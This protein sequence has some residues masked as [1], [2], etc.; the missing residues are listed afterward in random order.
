MFKAKIKHGVCY[1][2]L[3]KQHSTEGTPPSLSSF[4]EALLKEECKSA[5][6]LETLTAALEKNERSKSQEF[7]VLVGN[8]L[9]SYDHLQSFRKGDHP[10]VGSICMKSYTAESL[11]F[12]I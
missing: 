8:T 6:D 9:S 3:W 11:V 12:S 7:C 5:R 4:S 2:S 1:G 10:A